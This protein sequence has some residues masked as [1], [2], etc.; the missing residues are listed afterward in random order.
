MKFDPLCAL[1]AAPVSAP[2]SYLATHSALT[3]ALNFAHSDAD[4]A[5]ELLASLHRLS[6]RMAADVGE[7]HARVAFPL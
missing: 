4:L 5:K 1:Q 6:A 7:H 2:V 3:Q